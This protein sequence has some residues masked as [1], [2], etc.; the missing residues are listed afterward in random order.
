MKRTYTCS[1]CGERLTLTG[2]KQG[3][4]QAAQLWAQ[5]HLHEQ[6]AANA[7]TATQPKADEAQP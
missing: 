3:I 7:Q 1:I 6:P 4:A 5:G 2:T